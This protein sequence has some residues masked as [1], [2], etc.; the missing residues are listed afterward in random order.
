M[1]TVRVRIAV[2]VDAGGKWHATGS[3]LVSDD[4]S[5]EWVLGVMGDGERHVSVYHVECDVPIPDP[6]TIEGRVAT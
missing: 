6:Q 3:S 1:K 2:A 5:D 4:F